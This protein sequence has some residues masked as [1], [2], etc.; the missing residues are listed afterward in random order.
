MPLQKLEAIIKDQFRVGPGSEK[1]SSGE[2]ELFNTFDASQTLSKSTFDTLTPGMSIT[3]AIIIGKYGEPCLNKC[4][5]VGCNSTRIVTNQAGG[6]IWYVY[7][8]IAYLNM[9]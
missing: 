8:E 2:Y 9:C 6:L 1:V 7:V 3:M 5:R 4:P